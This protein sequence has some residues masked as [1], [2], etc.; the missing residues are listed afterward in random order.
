MKRIDTTTKATDL[1]GAGKHGFRDGDP[2]TGTPAT[3]LNAAIFNHLQEEVA[4]VIEGAGAALD[5]NNYAQMLAAIQTLI[6]GA[7]GTPYD[8][9][10][11]AGFKDDGTG[12]DLAVQEYGWFVSPR[13]LTIKG[14]QLYLGTAG[15]GAKPTFDVLK[16][17]VSVY[18]TKPE[19][20]ISANAGTAGVLTT[21]AGVA[22][23]AGDRLD[24]KC[25]QVGSTIKGQKARFTLKCVLA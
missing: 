9:G 11:Q 1:F 19:C 21:P 25:T 12:L 18:G 7:V 14:E 10:F 22:V 16:N 5:S 15:T 17:G 20:A 4:R 24:F 3:Q 8:V 6:A 23:A 2:L 13:P